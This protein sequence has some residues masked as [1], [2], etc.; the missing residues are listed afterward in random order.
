VIR[1]WLLGVVRDV[2]G[3]LGVLVFAFACSAPFILAWG[4]R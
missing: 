2:L 3:T 1:R 4:F